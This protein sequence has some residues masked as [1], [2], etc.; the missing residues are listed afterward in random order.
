MLG[1]F[2]YT[3]WLTYLSLISSVIGITQAL[4]GAG[5]PMLG[6]VCLLFCGL[7]DA[8]D[9]KV[10]RT[11]KDRPAMENAF[12][13][14]IDSLSDVAAF[15]ILPA[16]IGIS[17]L[18]TSPFM[19]EHPV[20]NG[21]GYTVLLLYALAALIRL[22]YFNVTEE[23][24]QRAEGGVRKYYT[25]LP[26]TGAA[27]VFPLMV[28]LWKLCTADVTILY[29]LMAALMGFLFLSKLQMPKP[30][31][32]GILVMVAIGAVEFAVLALIHTLRK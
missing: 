11:K 9:G 20:V 4:S 13:I 5:R 29:V 24:R 8:F 7:F 10:A 30:K 32:K 31:L 3:V 6:M 19:A 16:C 25:G 18:H 2:D 21:I 12:G 27:L 1:F 15:G 26:V 28:I 14:Q 17:L 23:E 22:G